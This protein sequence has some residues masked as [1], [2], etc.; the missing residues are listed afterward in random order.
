MNKKKLC[1]IIIVVAAVVLVSVP[2]IGKK[3]KSTATPSDAIKNEVLDG[4]KDEQ[5]RQQEEKSEKHA[6]ISSYLYG[7]LSEDDISLIE[8]H[9]SLEKADGGY[10]LSSEYATERTKLK[11]EIRDRAQAIVEGASE[12][13]IS[14]DVQSGTMTVSEVTDEVREIAGL[15]GMY[16]KVSNNNYDWLVLINVSG[17][18]YVTMSDE[19]EK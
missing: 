16:Q 15:L 9:A 7:L 2:L 14:F 18:G 10:T 6:D 19:G 1:C 4:I 3:N 13:S 5:N 12:T 11:T 17:G 8:S